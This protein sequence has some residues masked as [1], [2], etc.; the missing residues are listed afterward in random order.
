MKSV[1]EAPRIIEQYVLKHLMPPSKSSLAVCSAMELMRL[2][3]TKCL[4]KTSHGLEFSNHFII[5]LEVLL[6]GFIDRPH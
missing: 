6:R 3:G 5:D 4:K 2:Y 1:S